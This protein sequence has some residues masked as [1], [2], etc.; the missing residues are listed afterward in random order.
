ML[1][2]SGIN[3]WRTGVVMRLLLSLATGFLVLGGAVTMDP[4][5]Y[6]WLLVVNLVYGAFVWWIGERADVWLDWLNLIF[7]TTMTVAVLQMTG[8]SSSPFTFL[9]YFWLFAMLLVN[10]RHGDLR[11]L[12]LLS[13]L[14]LLVFALGSWGDPGMQSYLLVNG[15]GVGM[16]AFTAQ[17]LLLER[18]LGR[19]DPLTRVLHRGAGLE[20]LGEKMRRRESFDLAFVDLKGF[21]A[22]ND[23]YGHAIGDEVLSGLAGRLAACVRAR[24]LVIRYGGDEFLV[25]GAVSTLRERLKEVFARPL[26]TTLGSVRIEGDVGV[27]SWTPEVGTDLDDLLA[28]ADAEMYRMKYTVSREDS[29]RAGGATIHR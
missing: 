25:V 8:R 15:L 28:R 21:K 5:A 18:R 26:A 16:F 19:L 17:K 7:D 9:V 2:R 10:A 3:Q 24:D 14:A 1:Q 12:P 29:K 6:R 20:R 13:G 23:A 4:A 27:V 11:A 22:I